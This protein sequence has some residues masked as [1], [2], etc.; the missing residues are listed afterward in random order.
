MLED[1]NQTESDEIK[2]SDSKR[3]RKNMSKNFQCMR[4]KLGMSA[5]N[6]AFSMETYKTSVWIRRMFMTSSMKAA[7]HLGPNF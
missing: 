3:S 4:K 5:V 7:I 1:Q 6:A 2:Y